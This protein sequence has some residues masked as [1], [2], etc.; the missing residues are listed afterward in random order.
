VTIINPPQR[1]KYNMK[2]GKTQKKKRVKRNKNN[3]AGKSNI[4][5]VLGEKNSKP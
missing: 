2:T 1:H 5:D 3:M 4:N